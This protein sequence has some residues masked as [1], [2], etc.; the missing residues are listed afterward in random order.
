M[1]LPNT[2]RSGASFK[3]ELVKGSRTSDNH[4]IFLPGILTRGP[5]SVRP[6]QDTLSAVGS[7]WACTYTARRWEISSLAR[8]VAMMTQAIM[9][10]GGKVTF[11]GVSIG[12]I[13]TACV[14]NHLNT[15]QS[16]MVRRSFIVDAPYG[17]DTVMLPKPLRSLFASGSYQLLAGPV[18]QGLLAAFRQ[19]PKD[20]NIE[21]PF[22][23][24]GDA[25][26]AAIKD[27]AIKNLKGYKWNQYGSQVAEILKTP[28]VKGLGG[29]EA[30]YIANVGE[31]NDT[32]RQP[33]AAEGWKSQLPDLVVH[34]IPGVAHAGF[35][36]ASR[37]W[38]EHLARLLA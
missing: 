4:V 18:G 17:A 2:V 21:V 32:V 27:E 29:I 26:R 13:L 8:E 3:A 38:N 5:E 28:Y 24:D 10:T 31:Q 19:P 14:A 15:R 37:T 34:E 30:T 23:E 9:E 12:G 6:I 7:V 16:A 1:S 22:G 20:L 25:Y 11:F 35:L 36:E 33:L